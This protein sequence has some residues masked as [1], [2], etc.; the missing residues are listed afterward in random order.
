MRLAGVRGED[1]Q[2]GVSGGEED[3]AMIHFQMQTN[4]SFSVTMLWI[5]FGSKML[6]RIE[7]TGSEN[8]SGAE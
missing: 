2:D 3:I 5:L 7:K 6:G 4:Y 1:A 8:E